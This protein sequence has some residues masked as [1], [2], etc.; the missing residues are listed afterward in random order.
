MQSEKSMASIR[1]QTFK[2]GKQKSKQETFFFEK[3]ERAQEATNFQDLG[4][5]NRYPVQP[6]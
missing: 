5:K 2:W 4:V 1:N 3:K 6:P